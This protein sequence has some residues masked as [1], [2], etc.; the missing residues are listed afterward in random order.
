MH[1]SGLIAQVFNQFK[2]QMNMVTMLQA[3]NTATEL[4]GK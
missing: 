3:M 2:S 4:P 1:S